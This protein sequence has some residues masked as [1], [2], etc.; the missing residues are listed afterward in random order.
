MNN[1]FI[2]GIE[3]AVHIGQS[4]WQK[5]ISQKII[6]NI[7]WQST[8]EQNICSNTNDFEL[9]I[10]NIIKLASSQHWHSLT[11]LAEQIKLLIQSQISALNFQITLTIPHAYAQ[12]KSFGINIAYP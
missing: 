12:T 8:L 11:E 3:C 10:K 2:H 9:T 6:I 7:E 1:Y 5:S 4:D